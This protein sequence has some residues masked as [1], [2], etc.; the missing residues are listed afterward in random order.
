MLVSHE[1]FARDR[2]GQ[3]KPEFREDD[4]AIGRGAVAI[5]RTPPSRSAWPNR[6]WRRRRGA[7]WTRSASKYPDLAGKTIKHR[8]RSSRPALRG[9]SVRIGLRA[10]RRPVR[11]TGRP[12]RDDAGRLAR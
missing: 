7:S 12:R 8:C 11:T 3:P 1:V 9:R 5:P 2:Q 10:A 6:A 4:H